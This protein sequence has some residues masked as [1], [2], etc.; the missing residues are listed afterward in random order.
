LTSQVLDEGNKLLKFEKNTYEA[1]KSLK[2]MYVDLTARRRW[3]ERLSGLPQK[4]E[5]LAL[6]TLMRELHAFYASQSSPDLLASL[7]SYFHSPSFGLFLSLQPPPLSCAPTPLFSLEISSNP[8][9]AKPVY[10][11][12]VSA[13]ALLGKDADSKGAGVV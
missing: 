7:P 5:L 6:L 12:H 4:S 11:K 3:E 13:A 8:L 10:G 9:V 2:R 1:D